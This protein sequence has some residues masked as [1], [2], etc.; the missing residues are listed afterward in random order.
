MC[1]A[2]C[3]KT[4]DFYF[5][6][7]LDY[8]Y[9]YLEEV[10]VTPRNFEFN[11]R[12]TEPLRSHYAMIGMAYIFDGYPLYYDAANER[13]LAMA[14]LSLPKS[15]HYSKIMCGRENIAQFGSCIREHPEDAQQLHQLE[16][17][18]SHK[19]SRNLEL[20]YVSYL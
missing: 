5:G 12:H 10:T 18:G 14:A 20:L 6:R 4:K 1:T 11:L 15:A 13:G 8:D 19:S 16:G 2:I 3:F 9:S 17:Q 7:T